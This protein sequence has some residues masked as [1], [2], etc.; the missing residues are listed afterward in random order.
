METMRLKTGANSNPKSVAGAIANNVKEGK[1]VEIVAM[2]AAAVNVA[3]K[4]IAI[5]NEF[6]ANDG[7]VMLCKPTFTHL[8]LDGEEKSAMVLI[9][10][11]NKI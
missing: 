1:Q 2:G 9:I 5:C 10:Q 8:T 6:S 4:A 11:A 7:Y 3:M